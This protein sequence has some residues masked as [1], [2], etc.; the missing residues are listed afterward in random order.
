MSKPYRFGI[1]SS[2]RSAEGGI[3]IT[4]AGLE[5]TLGPL[6]SVIAGVVLFLTV[7]LVLKLLSLLVAVWRDLERNRYHVIYNASSPCLFALKTL[8]Y[9]EYSEICGKN[10][11]SA[12]PLRLAQGE[13]GGV[14]LPGVLGDLR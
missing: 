12:A 7:W 4:V 13:G 11:T 14:D 1:S 8:R 10:A 2:L 6:Q 5:F 3:Q 9:S